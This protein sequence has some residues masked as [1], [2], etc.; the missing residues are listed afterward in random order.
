MNR[1]G[2]RLIF[3]LDIIVLF[4][5]MVLALTGRWDFVLAL[6]IGLVLMN[7]FDGFWNKRGGR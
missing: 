7:T 3:W 4:A 1:D 5:A 2:T 6:A